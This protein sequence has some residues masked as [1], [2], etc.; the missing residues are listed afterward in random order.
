MKIYIERGPDGKEELRVEGLSPE[1]Q[2]I[3]DERKFMLH[4]KV[5]T[6]ARPRNAKI[7]EC[8]TCGKP[9]IVW[10]GS[11]GMRE[12]IV[13]F[14][15]LLQGWIFGDRG[16]QCPACYEGDIQA[17]VQAAGRLSNVPS[18]EVEG[19]IAQMPEIEK[20]GL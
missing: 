1:Q 19:S 2:Q 4:M 10:V 20:E 8:F 13:N 5:Q 14:S 3:F 16:Y 6:S 12:M 17:M 9:G 15:L 18:N 11:K 7:V